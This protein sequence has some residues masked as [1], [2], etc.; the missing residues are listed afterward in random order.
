MV[1][2]TRAQQR[3]ATFLRSVRL[4]LGDVPEV[5]EEWD[6]LDDLERA[7]WSLDWAHEILD[8]WADLTESY[9]NGELLPDQ[10]EAY[11]QLR[12]DLE[13]ARP[14]L[15]RLNIA[16]PPARPIEPEVMLPPT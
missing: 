12:D 9:R 1:A 16:R 14:T 15:E 7:S 13:V 4:M 11:R 8:I 3:A 5:A 2:T 10:A 6:A